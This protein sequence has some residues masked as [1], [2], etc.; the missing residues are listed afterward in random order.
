MKT[1]FDFND[2]QDRTHFILID[3]SFSNM[4]VVIVDPRK[5]RVQYH[6]TGEWRE[7]FKWISKKLTALGLGFQN[8]IAIVENPNLDKATFDMYGLVKKAFQVKPFDEAA[9]ENARKVWGIAS[10]YAQ[11]VG[12]SKSSGQEI[13][14]ALVAAKVPVIEVAPSKRQKA[15]EKVWRI[16]PLT[17]K[18]EKVEVPIMK[19]IKLL[20]LKKPTKTNAEQYKILTKYNGTSSEHSRDA[21][22]L[23]IG[24]NLVWARRQV[25]VQRKAAGKVPDSFPS[26]TN[27]NTFLLKRKPKGQEEE[28]YEE[29]DLPF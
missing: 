5:F 18:K 28:P 21:G 29:P 25:E 20:G 12:K 15:K 2:L 9:E 17:D 19:Q 4:G 16:N 6:K 11:K 8:L 27:H 3:P 22:T 7:T 10:N 1:P 24:V 13:I 26:S 14:K 23:G